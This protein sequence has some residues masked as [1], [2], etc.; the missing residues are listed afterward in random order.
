MF[1]KY[2]GENTR[3]SINKRLTSKQT[4][5][6][7]S[8]AYCRQDCRNKLKIQYLLHEKFTFKHSIGAMETVE[9]NDKNE[10]TLQR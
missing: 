10:N 2:A 1:S 8:T 7:K 6:F 4:S 3:S 9:K 5:Q